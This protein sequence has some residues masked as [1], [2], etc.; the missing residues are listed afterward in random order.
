MPKVHICLF[1]RLGEWLFLSSQ[2]AMKVS[3]FLLFFTFLGADAARITVS[4]TFDDG[5]CLPPY[6]TYC[7][8][9]CLLF[10]GCDLRVLSSILLRS[11]M[12]TSLEFSTGVGW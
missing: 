6:S 11:A 4:L 1:G 10:G 2:R 12:G 3:I 8:A 9:V 5:W 7:R